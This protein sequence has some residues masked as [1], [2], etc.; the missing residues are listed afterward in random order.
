MLDAGE[1]AAAFA[2]PRPGGVLEPVAGAWTNR[3]FRLV[4]GGEAY[5]VKELR[6]PWELPE[7]YDRIDE[8]WRV[9]LLAIEAGVPAPVPVANP[10]TGGWRADV[11]GPGGDPVPVRLHRWVDGEVVPREPTSEA[12]ARW[13]GEVLAAIHGL[14]LQPERPEVFP[15]RGAAD[16]HRWPALVEAVD[17]TGVAWAELAHRA[18]PAVEAINHVL[19]DREPEATRMGHRDID[20]KNL[21]LTAAGP[22]LCDWDVAGPE[23]PRVELADV[24]VSMARWERPEVARAV[25]DGYRRAGGHHEPITAAD[26]APTLRSAYDWVVL[27]VERA[28]A[29]RGTEVDRRLGEEH[30]PELLAALPGRVEAALRIEAFLAAGT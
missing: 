11:A 18:T 30:A 21:L 1:V 26:L 7:W 22:V 15:A 6:N 2:L 16:L 8:A 29:R 10:Q 23:E 12:V 27:N 19:R 9:E 28:L 4:A 17:A 14:A 5:A 3:V 13:C 20:Q 25:L 24:A